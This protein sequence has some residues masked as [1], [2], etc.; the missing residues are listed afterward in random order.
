MKRKWLR[1][2]VHF[3]R[4][5]PLIHTL[6]AVAGIFVIFQNCGRTGSTVRMGQPYLNPSATTSGSPGMG[7][8]PTPAVMSSPLPPGQSSRIQFPI[9]YDPAGNRLFDPGRPF[10]LSVDADSN[11]AIAAF[12][13]PLVYCTATTGVCS[14]LFLEG[15]NQNTLR[16]HPSSPIGVVILPDSRIAYIDYL[17]KTLQVQVRSD[18]SRAL[19][20]QA[21]PLDFAPYGIASDTSGSRVYITGEESFGA[22]CDL[23][24]S[25]SKASCKHAEGL[26]GFDVTVDSSGKLY[27]ANASRIQV[28]DRE[29]ENCNSYS[30]QDERIMAVGIAAGKD[31]MVSDYF[32][33]RVMK[34]SLESSRVSCS[35]LVRGLQIPRS[36][37]L[38]QSG[39]IYIAEYKT[40]RIIRL[41]PEGKEF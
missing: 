11:L 17:G 35:D 23:G 31:L 34:C 10:G 8:S 21:T 9:K 38:D 14:N 39:N 12:E 28:C 24:T 22:F 26:A 15:R 3:R 36:I 4:N 1:V 6:A 41:S 29:V 18:D 13:G 25:D 40:G 19:T 33:S 16:P 30:F 37:R 2:R 5:I 20:W 7:A 27:V 32:Q